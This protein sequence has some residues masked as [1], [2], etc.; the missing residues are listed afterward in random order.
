MTHRRERH[1]VLPML[2]GAFFLACA[3]GC[4]EDQPIGD[5]LLEGVSNAIS[6]LAEAALLTFVL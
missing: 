6:T 3:Q 4:R 5:A 1:R 2:L